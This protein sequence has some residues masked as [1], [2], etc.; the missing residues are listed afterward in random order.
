MERIVIMRGLPGSGKTHYVADLVRRNA[1]RL[2]GTVVVS[3]DDYFMVDSAYRFDPAKLG[4]AHAACFRRFV[5]Q[6]AADA[7]GLST[8]LVVDNTNSTAWEISPYVLAASAYAPNA[9]VEIV[10][11]SCDP[12]VAFA[13][14]QHG[15]P[16]AA[17]DAM[18]R[19]FASIADLPPW[20][21]VVAVVS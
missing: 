1:E 10:S 6:L 3:A 21:K 19:R 18:A 8:T 11:V 17:F 2:R 4:E 13:R 9:E 16:R 7:H 12:E 15:V 14:Q 5:G 20:W